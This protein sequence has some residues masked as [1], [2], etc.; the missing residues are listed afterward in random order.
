MQT[1]NYYLIQEKKRMV[2]QNIMSKGDV[3]GNEKVIEKE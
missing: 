2:E 3:N 1:I